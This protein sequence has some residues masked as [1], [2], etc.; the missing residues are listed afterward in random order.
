[1][2]DKKLISVHL[3]RTGGTSFW[4]NLKWHFKDDFLPDY[5]DMEIAEH[6]I[7]LKKGLFRTVENDDPLYERNRY[8]LQQALQIADKGVGN[9]RCVHGHMMAAKYLLLASKEDWTFVTWM[10]EPVS[11]LISYYNFWI[12]NFDPA[13]DPDPEI[14][15]YYKG[16][17]TLEKFCLN[18]LFRNT[19]QKY[20]WGFPLDNFEFIGLTEHFEDDLV[21]FAR[22]YLGKEIEEVNLNKTKAGK[23]AAQTLDPG[24]RKEVEAFHAGDVALY[25]RAVAMRKDRLG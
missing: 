6:G 16:S 25:K 23:T 14:Q 7:V 11:R 9:A 2:P 12:E 4:L 15:R 24:F 13:N 1:M 17:E 3:P 20:L 10:R 21:Y 18:P 22:A 5:A 19:C 8:I